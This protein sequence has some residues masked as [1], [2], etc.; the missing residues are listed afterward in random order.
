[1][2]QTGTEQSF[3]W[4]RRDMLALLLGVAI[5]PG[6][7]RVAEAATAAEINK[8]ADAAIK[9]LEAQ[10]PNYRA[11]LQKALGVLIFPK[12]IKGGLI[13]GGEYGEGALR[14]NGKTVR[15]YRIAA[16]SLGL[17]AGGQSFSYALLFMKQAALDYLHKSDGWAVGSGPSVVVMDKGMAASMTSTT[18]T[19]DVIAIP[20]G[21][22]GLM[23]GLSLE[24]SKITPINPS[25]T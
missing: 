8:D 17:Q 10:D 4:V 18:V 3:R 15:Y 16:A 23:A 21:Q 22:S 6:C 25:A 7:F 1:M 13:I 5:V 2:Q 14:E 24:G 12:I 20:F 19:Q 11:L 9:Q